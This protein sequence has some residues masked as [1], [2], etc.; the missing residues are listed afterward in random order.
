MF[1]HPGVIYLEETRS[2]SHLQGRAHC[3]CRYLA[4][5]GKPTQKKSPKPLGFRDL[6][7]VAGGGFAAGPE[8]AEGSKMLSKAK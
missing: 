1:V 6:N 8:R 3:R 4:A 5:E 2:I 7:L